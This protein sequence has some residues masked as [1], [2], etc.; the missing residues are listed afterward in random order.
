M[1]QVIIGNHHY[2]LFLSFAM[3]HFILHYVT[4][5]VYDKTSDMCE[6][7]DVFNCGDGGLCIPPE[8]KCNGI[9]ECHNGADESVE[10]CG[11]CF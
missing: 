10:Q 2:S 3:L 9:S 7:E 5:G 8:Q 11:G 4:D 6:K 1:Q